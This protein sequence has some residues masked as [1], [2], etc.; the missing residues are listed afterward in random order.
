MPTVAGHP[1]E[2]LTVPFRAGVG[3]MPQVAGYDL[4]RRIGSGGMGVVWE[5]HEHRFD[6]G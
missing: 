1:S 5:A 2:A 3:A 4:V 6:D